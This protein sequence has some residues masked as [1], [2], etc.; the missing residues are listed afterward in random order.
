MDEVIP[1]FLMERLAEV[2]EEEFFGTA[3]M[4]LMVLGYSPTEICRTM[5]KLGEL[6]GHATGHL[7][8]EAGQIEVEVGTAGY[9]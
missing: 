2:D 8:A 1:G 3:P 5:F 7:C 4:L 9:L 6:V